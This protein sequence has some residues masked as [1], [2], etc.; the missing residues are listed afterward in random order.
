MDPDEVLKNILKQAKLIQKLYDNDKHE[1]ITPD[2]STD[3]A[4]AIINLD[5]WLKSG[6]FLPSRWVSRK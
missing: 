4:Y 1:Q 5:S 2:Q 6:G 3:L